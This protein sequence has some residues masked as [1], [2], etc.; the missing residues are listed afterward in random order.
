MASNYAGQNA[1]WQEKTPKICVVTYVND[2]WSFDRDLPFP[3]PAH[4]EAA[5]YEKFKNQPE[6][7]DRNTT[8]IKS[9]TNPGLYNGPYSVTEFKLGSHVVLKPNPSFFGA[10]PSIAKIV[11]THISDTSA[12]RANLISQQ[13]D[14]VSAVGFPADVAISM[15]EE[16]EKDHLPV[17]VRFQN[18]SIFQGLFLQMENDQLKDVRVRKALALAL[19]KSSFTKA[20]FKDKIMAANTFLPPQHPAFKQRASEFSREK[21]KK[22]LDEAGW[23][24]SGDKGLRQKNGKNLTLQF[25]TSAGIKIYENLQQLLCDQFK[26][27]GV[28]CEIKNEPPRILLGDSVPKG[29]FDI[30]MFGQ[31]IL[32]DSSMT[33]SF[34][35]KEIPS[36]KNSWAGGNVGRWSN[37][38]VDELLAQFDQEWSPSKRNQ[39]VTKIEGIYLQER[40]FIPLYHRREAMVIPRGLTGV[41]DDIAGTG[42]VFPERW[43]WK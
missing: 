12:L 9:P 14:V 2:D 20:F 42:F 15:S 23:K 43:Q 26:Q 25:K 21:A 33:S 22:L 27:I 29:Q 16:F 5:V 17:M 28:S 3:I 7:Y 11:V 36:A 6:G 34:S 10:A 32:P 38:K 13:V 4:L 30:A 18:S 24:V 39:I 35:S 1:K 31:P 41:Q 19:D 37:T 40:P 8:Y